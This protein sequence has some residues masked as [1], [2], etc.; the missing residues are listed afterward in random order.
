M[1]IYANGT[2]AIEYVVK[3]SVDIMQ[4]YD[5]LMETKAREIVRSVVRAYEVDWFFGH[6]AIGSQFARI[7]PGNNV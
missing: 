2:Q 7:S 1:K 3:N 5:G 4:R 6:C